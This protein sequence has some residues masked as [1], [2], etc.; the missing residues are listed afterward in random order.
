[1][2]VPRRQPRLSQALVVLITVPVVLAASFLALLALNALADLLLP[3]QGV[4][5]GHD[6]DA[7]GVPVAALRWGLA[8]MLVGGYA[9]VVRTRLPDLLK[10]ILLAAP[11]GVLIASLLV[12]FFDRPP[13]GFGGAVLVAIVT[14]VLLR[15]L[16]KPWA[17]YLAAAEAV[18]LAVFYGWPR[19]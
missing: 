1:M 2:D 17:Y 16:G 6:P 14:G 11:V 4:T 10:A 15:V 5:P 9:L 12:T 18:A 13:L 7:G 19:P 3:A 8:V